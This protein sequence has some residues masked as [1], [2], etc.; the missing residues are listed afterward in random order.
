MWTKLFLHKK[1]QKKS[2]EPPRRQDAKEKSNQSFLAVFPTLAALASW[3]F[4]LFF[5]LKEPVASVL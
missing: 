4:K 3:R 2:I 5:F 1:F